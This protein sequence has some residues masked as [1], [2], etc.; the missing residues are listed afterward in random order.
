MKLKLVKYEHI[1]LLKCVNVLFI[2]ILVILNGSILDVGERTS[3]QTLYMPQ[4]IFSSTNYIKGYLWESNIC[5][6]FLRLPTVHCEVL[7]CHN[8]HL[9]LLTKWLY[10]TLLTFQHCIGFWKRQKR[11]QWLLL[12][13][14]QMLICP[15]LKILTIVILCG[16]FAID[17]S[18]FWMGRA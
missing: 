5:H 9:T 7:M 18:I 3:S 1:F 4:D 11:L 12:L 10:L 17:Q 8:R 16:L 15:S 6:T 2:E 13:S 14:T